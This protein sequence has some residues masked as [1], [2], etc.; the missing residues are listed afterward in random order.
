ISTKTAKVFRKTIEELLTITPWRRSKETSRQRT[1]LPPC[2]SMVAACGRIFVRQWI[3]TGTLPN[4]G[5]LSRSATWPH[6]IFWEGELHKITHRPLSGFER[7]LRVVTRLASKSLRG[8]ITPGPVQFGIMQSQGSCCN[9]PRTK[10]IP[11]HKWTW[12]ISTSKVRAFLL[13]MSPHICGTKR[14]RPE[15]SRA[16]GR[17]SKACQD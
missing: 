9:W 16:H 15:D 6:S 17:N 4:A 8:C 5:M 12:D 2:M 3:G 10:G 1:I 11:V 13:T 14:Q 7:P